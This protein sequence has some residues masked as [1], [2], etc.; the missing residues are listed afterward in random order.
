M[1]VSVER[2]RAYGLFPDVNRDDNSLEGRLRTIVE[3]A[4]GDAIDRQPFLLTNAGAS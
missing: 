2:S 4:F 1:P 3:V